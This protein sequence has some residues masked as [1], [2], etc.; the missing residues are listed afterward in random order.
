MDQL[1][2]IWSLQHTI[3]HHLT[4]VNTNKLTILQQKATCKL[5]TLLQKATGRMLCSWGNC[6]LMTLA[7]FINT[8]IL[9]PNTLPL[10][11]IW[12]LILKYSHLPSNFDRP[13]QSKETQLLCKDSRYVW[14]VPILF[15]SWEGKLFP[16][17]LGAP[18][19]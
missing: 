17:I 4:R 12:D 5:I 6:R 16:K 9:C 3:D 8:C 10:C 18:L 1:P 11:L 19:Y 13:R 7:N 14:F 2:T 15:L